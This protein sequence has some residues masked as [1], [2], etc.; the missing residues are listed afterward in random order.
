MAVL[1]APWFLDAAYWRRY[2]AAVF[3]SNAALATAMPPRSPRFSLISHPHRAT[4]RQHWAAAP[5]VTFHLA[6]PSLDAY[7]ALE[8][9]I[10]ARAAQRGLWFHKG[11][12]FGFRGHRY[13]VVV[14]EAGQGAPFL[15]VAMGARGGE[16][17]RGIIRLMR[18]IALAIPE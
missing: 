15:R 13:E 2:C 11:G 14:P 16:M 9:E 1:E 3:S 18:D 7:R 10:A 17:R 4:P 5:F 6:R 8:A 12:S